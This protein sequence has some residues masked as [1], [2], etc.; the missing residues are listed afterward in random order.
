M[1]WYV[2][3]GSALGG[4]ARYLLAGWA[5][6]AVDSTFPMGTLVVNIAGS[7]LL[8]FILRY[9]MDLAS[10]STEMRVFLTIGFC[11]GFTT[12]STFSY[13]AIALL[14]EGQWSRA[15]VYILSSVAVSLAATLAGLAVAQQILMHA[16]QA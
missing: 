3:A 4:M 1:I 7:F 11:G 9:T 6:R 2:A 12:F 13:E 14:Q 8:G 5:Q 15:S 10:M 16:R